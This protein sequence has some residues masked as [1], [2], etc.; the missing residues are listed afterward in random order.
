MHHASGLAIP[1]H[2]VDAIVALHNIAGKNGVLNNADSPI[3]QYVGNHYAARGIDHIPYSNGSPIKAYVLT[4]QPEKMHIHAEYRGRLANMRFTPITSLDELVA[5]GV[6]RAV[7]LP[8]IRLIDEP[9]PDAIEWQRYGLPPTATL[10]LKD[11]VYIHRWLAENGYAQFI[12]NFVGCGVGEIPKEASRML[13]K[14]ST[15]YGE[16]GM[17]GRYPL[18]V[19][20]RGAFSDG[21]YSMAAIVEAITDMSLRD[22]S[23]KRGQ[24]MIKP[25]GNS[26]N[27][28]VVDTFAEALIRV[29][30]MFYTELNLDEGSQVI[31]SRLLD[32]DL[33]PGLCAVITE[34]APHFM[35]FNG[36]YMAPGN[37]ACTGTT[38][39]SS[40]I[41]VDRAH[42]TSA[43][44]L[45]Q[46]HELLDGIL[47]SFL[48]G[49]DTSSLYAMMNIDV[50]MVGELEKELHQRAQAT[51]QSRYLSNLGTCDADY[52][53]RV[54]DPNSI[55]FA[56]I[57]PRDTNW[58]L[59]MKAVLQVLHQPCTVENLDNLA[60]GND[61]QILARDHWELP[62]GMSIEDARD[63]LT[64]YH[65]QLA[66]QGE[67][68]I[69]RMADNPAGIIIYTPSQDR[70]RL[71]QISD[72]A[73]KFLSQHTASP[74][75]A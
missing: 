41:G 16:L 53:P 74:V 5:R 68:M 30:D 32:I 20:I 44:Y 9:F 6:K 71:E 59:A 40:A 18:G 37:T 26:S 7:H 67:G 43:K 39:F 50:M 8:Y 14:I 34:G 56:E 11:K 15:M 12:P 60:D 63:L 22:L 27:L 65:Y 61:I 35:E 49:S 21:N 58:T 29:Q 10:H 73:H 62:D 55:L 13:N 33:S 75:P 52:E 23:I 46:T 2:N 42:A 64:E 4:N 28:E 38:T 24:V 54:Y 1:L 3:T 69:M 70:G 36:Q 19:I 17:L 48:A 57:N 72:D 66:E 47:K 51:P 45:R 31:M 25:N